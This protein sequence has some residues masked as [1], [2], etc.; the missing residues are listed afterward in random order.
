M[1]AFWTALL[2]KAIAAL[3]HKDWDAV[4]SSVYLLTGAA[5]PGEQKREQVFI[6]LRE[7]GVS[8]ATWLLYAA[9]EIA[10]GQLKIKLEKQNG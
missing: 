4:V 7:A 3:L 2:Q 10:Y 8:V 9:I 6:M 1:Q 5:I